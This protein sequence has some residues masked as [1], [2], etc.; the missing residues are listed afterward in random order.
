M[1]SAVKIPETVSTDK[2]GHGHCEGRM[3]EAIFTAANTKI[4]PPGAGSFHSSQ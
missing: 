4:V 3:P 1:Y 2:V